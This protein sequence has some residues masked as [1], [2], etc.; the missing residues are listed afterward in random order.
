MKILVTGAAGFIGF[1]TTL[2]L[3]A[4][5]H[6]VIG[7]DNLNNYYDVRLKQDRL[8]MLQQ[9][10]GFSFIRLD[11]SDRERVAH[12]FAESS[13][14][15]VLHLAAQAGVRYSL[16]NPFAY[17]DSNI[18][19][20]LTILEGCRHNGVKDLI[21]ASS[22]SVYG[23]NQKWPSAVSDRV[24]APISL[25]AATKKA[26]EL[27]CHTYSHLFGLRAT[28]L[29]FFTVYGPWGRPDMAYFRFAKSIIDGKPIDVFNHGDMKRDFT[30]IDDIT[31]GIVGVVAAHV[32]GARHGHKVY[33]L[34]NNQ[35]EQLLQFIG[36]L[37]ELLGRTAVKNFLPMQPGDVY[38]TYADID[39]SARDFGFSPSVSLR[40][41]LSRFVQWFRAYGGA[42]DASQA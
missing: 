27:M 2:R 34:G 32:S 29:R 20:T 25:Y 19:G 31:S 26:D 21:Y 24:D 6:E 41:G 4:D 13:F 35:P 3:L 39:E 38:A 33:N 28:G 42:Q 15:L 7:V 23:A 12:L 37:E 9:E 30:Y 14:D 11:L 5:G 40:D 18:T 16:D 10:S 22:S 1:H 8:L 36:L 17:I